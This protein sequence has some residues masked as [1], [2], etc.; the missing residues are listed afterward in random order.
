MAANTE[1]FYSYRRMQHAGDKQIFPARFR[2]AM[3]RL[4]CFESPDI[5]VNGVRER[6]RVVME[7]NRLATLPM[8]CARQFALPWN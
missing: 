2:R 7:L 6:V 1:A 5:V 4:V 3:K 8:E